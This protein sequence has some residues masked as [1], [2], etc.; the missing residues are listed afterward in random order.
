[1]VR[2]E[3]PFRSRREAREQDLG[4]RLDRAAYQISDTLDYRWSEVPDQPGAGPIQGKYLWMDIRGFQG[5]AE[6]DKIVVTPDAAQG[7][8]DFER[9]V[10]WGGWGT[11]PLGPW[12]TSSST[13]DQY[14]AVDGHQGVVNQIAPGAN[15]DITLGVQHPFV[16][17]TTN[18]PID[19]TFTFTQSPAAVPQNGNPF[20]D[21]VF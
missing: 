2:P 5:R 17:A 16:N 15:G 13:Y 21:N 18:G 7:G 1:V 11:G 3:I 9:V 4:R 12:V 10:S 20:I 14:L 19:L 6:I 8:D